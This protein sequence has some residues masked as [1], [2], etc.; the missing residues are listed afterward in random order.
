MAFCSA[1]FF[2]FTF[3][4]QGFTVVE[5]DVVGPI[6]SSQLPKA[7]YETVHRPRWVNDCHE[8]MIKQVGLSCVCSK[9]CNFCV[10]M[11]FV[12]LTSL[13]CALFLL[14]KSSL[15]FFSFAR[16]RYRD[17]VRKRQ[18]ERKWKEDLSSTAAKVRFDHPRNSIQVSHKGGSYSNT[19]AIMPAVA[20]SASTG[21]WNQ[22]FCFRDNK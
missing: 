1:S 6:N 20:G 11:E 3:P 19:W 17:R 16:Q 21:S 10:S 12:Q 15:F 5:T 2:F 8:E 4:D 7:K 14:L 13:S 18:L 9:L 22:N